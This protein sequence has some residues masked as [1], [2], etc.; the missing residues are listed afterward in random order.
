MKHNVQ[1]PVAFIKEGKAII[2]FCPVLDLAA[3]GKTVEEAKK[4]FEETFLLFVQELEEKGTLED[5]LEE[6]GW[7]KVAP[8]F[9]KT[10]RWNPP[11]YIGNMNEEF[12]V[13]F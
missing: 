7:E 1:I 12:A 11:T 13:S 5:V 8:G 4:A 6:S 9:G 3:H 2:A 10:P